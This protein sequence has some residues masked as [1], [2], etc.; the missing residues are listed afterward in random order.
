MWG[1]GWRGRTSSSSS[2]STIICGEWAGRLSEWVGQ[3]LVAFCARHA[4]DGLYF[5]D[6]RTAMSVYAKHYA[7]Q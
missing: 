1:R 5:N 3:K 2:D 6:Q 7:K 4:P